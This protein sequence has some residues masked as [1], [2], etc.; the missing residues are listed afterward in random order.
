MVFR[1]RELVDLLSWVKPE[2]LFVRIQNTRDQDY[3]ELVESD[4]RG[5]FLG[6]RREYDNVDAQDRT[7]RIDTQPGPGGEMADGARQ[8][9]R[10][11]PC[12]GVSAMAGARR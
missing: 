11:A 9:Q 7:G 6:F 5:R 1:L 3:R 4:P 2:V 12:A 8:P 10:P